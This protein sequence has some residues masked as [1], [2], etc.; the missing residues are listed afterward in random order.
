MRTPLA[1]LLLVLVT[2]AHGFEWRSDLYHCSAI[3]PD[4]AGWMPVEAPRTPG[5]TVLIAMQNPAKQS[6]FGI[7]I[8][9]KIPGT[10]VAE[11]AVQQAFEGMLRKFGYQF[12]GHSTVNVAGLEWLQYQVRAGAGAQSVTGV[13]RFAA[14]G[15]Y[16]FSITLL[17][18]G[19]QEAAQDLE[20]Q[21]AAA[22]FRMLPATPAA[23][24]LAPAAG[25]NDTAPVPADDKRES[26]TSAAAEEPAAADNTNL[27][28]IWY[29]VGGLIVFLVLIKIIAG[30]SS[31][32][33]KR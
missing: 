4:S 30:G 20:L 31:G 8:V 15:G 6:V 16:V 27:R 26:K 18:G 10:R 3:L 14:S 28:M 19:G 24:P 2:A 33:K 9:D 5:L 25:K 32:P 12:A 17:R 21:N 13:V 7:N 1:L 23:P 11:P 22:S 29:G